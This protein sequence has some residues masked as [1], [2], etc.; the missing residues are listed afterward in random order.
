MVAA[1]DREAPMRL[2]KYLAHAGVASR[3]ASE[4]IVRAGR[5]TVAGEVVLDPARDVNEASGVRV[6]GRDV[7]GAEGRVVY[8][9]NKPAGVLSTAHDPF[10]RPTI[11][12]LVGEQ[13]RRLYPVGRLDADSTGLILLTNDGELAN[14]LTHPRYHVAKTYRVQVE[15]GPVAEAALRALRTGVE[16]EDGRT[17]PAKALSL[18]RDRLEIT[19]YEGRNRQVRRMC[20]AVGHPVAALQRVAFGPL[21]LGELRHGSHR[22]LSDAEVRSLRDASGGTL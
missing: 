16:L 17:A 14:R 8:A 1:D 22:R 19:I 15:M 7:C 18:G 10:G 21:R 6:D 5:V 11:V 20:E 4:Q 12:D 13:G 2:A 9:V 3:R